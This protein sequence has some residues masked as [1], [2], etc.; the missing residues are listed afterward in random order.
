MNQE[1]ITEFRGILEENGWTKL[2]TND[3]ANIKRKMHNA[4]RRKEETIEFRNEKMLTSFASHL[5]PHYHE[6]G[7]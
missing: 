6:Y 4:I 7:I 1:Q 2:S 5:L 3:I